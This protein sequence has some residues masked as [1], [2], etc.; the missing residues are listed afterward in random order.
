MKLW[1][2]FD[3]RATGIGCASAIVCVLICLYYNVILSWALYYIYNSFTTVL[4]WSE[5][6]KISENATDRIKECVDTSATEYFYYRVEFKNINY[7]VSIV[8][9]KSTLWGFQINQLTDN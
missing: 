5:C 8:Q 1:K 3:Y 6:P 7:M 2:K 9:S 4:P